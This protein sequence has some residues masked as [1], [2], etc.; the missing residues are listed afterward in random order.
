[1]NGKPVATVYFRETNTTQIDLGMVDPGTGAMLT[2]N[3]DAGLMHDNS[4]CRA[5]ILDRLTRAQGTQDEKAELLKKADTALERI[6]AG[7]AVR[8]D[9]LGI[10]MQP[11]LGGYMAELVGQLQA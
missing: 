5:R 2:V 7:E 9:R 1:M 4:D 8:T 10:D 3:C 6:S 11:S